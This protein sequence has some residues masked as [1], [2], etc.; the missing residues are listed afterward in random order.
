M[1]ELEAKDEKTAH[2]IT[3][4]LAPKTK[5][6]LSRETSRE[7]FRCERNFFVAWK[8]KGRSISTR[9]IN[10]YQFELPLSCDENDFKGFCFGGS[11]RWL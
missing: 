5:D 1:N 8:A 3:S 4:R 6:F 9:K 11:E 10:K 7:T 2:K